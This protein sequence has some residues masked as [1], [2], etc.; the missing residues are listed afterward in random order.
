MKK[1]N[2]KIFKNFINK[3]NK[4]KYLFTPGPG[5][6]T[7]ENLIHQQSCFG[8]ND[9]SYEKLENQVLRRLKIISGHKNIVRLQGSASLALEILINNFLFGKVLVVST[10]YYSD[11][12]KLLCDQSKKNFKNIKNIKS[13]SWENIS[14]VSEKFDW[15]IGC[16]TE[17]SMGLKVPILDLYKLKKRTKAKLALDATASI[18]LEKDHY[19][20]DVLAYSSCKGLFGLTGASFI[21]YNI[22]PNNLVESFYLSLKSHEDKKMTGPYHSILS[23]AGVLP[24]HEE[25]KDSVKINKLKFLKKMHLWL[26]KDKTNEPLLCTHTKYK[27]RNKEKN[28][29][30]YKTR[31]NIEGSVVCHLGELHLKSKAKGKILDLLK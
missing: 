29:I 31:L 30:L 21:A 7:A 6:L 28:V 26:T 20:S 17:T 19:Y 14:E 5:S 4:E 12:L 15:I 22:L 11:R 9:Q 13:I 8:R 24:V 27:F 18:G 10:G 1:E 25:I 16:P 3:K 23:L 2:T